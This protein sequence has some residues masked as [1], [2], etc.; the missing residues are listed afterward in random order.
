MFIDSDLKWYNHIK[1]ILN[2][3]VISTRIL[4]TVRHYVN[5]PSFIK[6]YYSFAYP[7]LKYEL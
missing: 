3:L 4:Y 2:K 6:I 1:Y 5:K 7:Y